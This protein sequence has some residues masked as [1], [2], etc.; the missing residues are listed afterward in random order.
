MRYGLIRKFGS[1]RTRYIIW[2]MLRATSEQDLLEL[3]IARE[4]AIVLA[5]G[6][7]R[8]VAQLNSSNRL[9]PNLVRPPHDL[10]K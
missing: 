4:L 5:S 10:R 2:T 3:R 1:C 7:N 6:L 9:R 8:N